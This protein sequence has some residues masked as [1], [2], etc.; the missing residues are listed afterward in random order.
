[1]RKNV[2]FCKWKFYSEKEHIEFLMSWFYGAPS[3]C[4]EQGLINR[5]YWT[6][7][8]IFIL[9]QRVIITLK[10][11]QCCRKCLLSLYMAWQLHSGLMMLNLCLNLYNIFNTYP[12][13]DMCYVTE[14]LVGGI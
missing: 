4:L 6:N 5:C 2:N 14:F 1:M 8:K 12:Q 10:R 13:Y 9:S 7:V 3:F 11:G